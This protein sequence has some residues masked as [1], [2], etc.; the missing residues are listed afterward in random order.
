[1]STHSIVGIPYGDGFRGRYVHCDGYPSYQARVLEELVQR[2]G[3]DQVVK[4]LTY[5]NYGWSHLDPTYGPDIDHEMYRDGRFRAVAGYGLAYTDTVLDFGGRKYQQTNEA[6]W[7]PNDNGDYCYAEWAYILT[8]QGRMGVFAIDGR[9]DET[10][11]TLTYKPTLIDF[12]PLDGSVDWKEIEDQ[13]YA[14][15]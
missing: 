13:V 10:T 9:Y 14:R 8:P 4:A 2:D 7:W 3:R 11:R 15:F 6:E 5:E 12:F 1:M